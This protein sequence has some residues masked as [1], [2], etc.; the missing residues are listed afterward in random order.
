MKFGKIQ[1]KFMK[2]YKKQFGITPPQ[3]TQIQSLF[4][5]EFV[6]QHKN[7]VEGSS[8]LIGKLTYLF[9]LLNIGMHPDQATELIVD[10]ALRFNKPFAI[11]PCCVFHRTFP[12][13]K[14]ANGTEVVQYQDF[15]TYLTEKDP[16]IKVEFLPF[17]GRNKILFKT[18][19][20]LI[21][22]KHKHRL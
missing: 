2:Q 4:G 1:H 22:C 14:T 15:I 6:E 7:L 18:Y 9:T 12:D 8:L 16:S 10:Y 19:I 11:I 20:S 5:E 21:Y 17:E 13:R 3:P